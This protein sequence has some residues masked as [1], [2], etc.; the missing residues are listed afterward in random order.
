MSNRN[1]RVKAIQ[2]SLTPRQTALMWIRK[3][4]N[5]TL[6]DGVRHSFPRRMIAESILKNVTNAMKGE[7]GAVVERAVR[8][9]RLEADTLYNLFIAVNISVL[10]STF[11]RKRECRFL[12][13]YL[14][15]ITYSNIGPHSEEEIRRTVLFFIEEI[16]LLDG[17]VS[18]VCAEHFGGQPLLFGNS[19]QQ[20]KEQLDVANTILECFN[21]LA[22]KLKFKELTEKSIRE[23][24]KGE[25]TMQHLAWLD[26]ARVETLAEFGDE[27]DRHAAYSRTLRDWHDRQAQARAKKA[28]SS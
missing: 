24:L 25:I 18:E 26:L 11:Q 9:A 16:F 27:A 13:Q 15:G 20:L 12:V 21:L 5:G 10:E 6:E 23:T 3:L 28:V 14:Q 7:P 19:V 4:A 2:L 22:D 8:Q 1:R 17:A